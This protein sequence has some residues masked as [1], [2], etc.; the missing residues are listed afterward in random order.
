MKYEITTSNKYKKQYR[1]QSEEDKDE[2]DKV[3]KKIANGEKLEKHNFDHDLK[4]KY[5]GFR[6]CHVKPDLL[7]I[8]R[9][10]KKILELYLSA[11]GSHSE[12]K[13]A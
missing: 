2:I 3:V 6:E 7:L 10:N 4:G 12:L 8:Y 1:K 9:I 11:V 5:V 13:L